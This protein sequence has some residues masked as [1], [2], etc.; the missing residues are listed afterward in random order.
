MH[1]ELVEQRKWISESRFLHALNYCMLLPGPEAQQLATYIGWLMHRTWGGI[2]A[3]TLFVLP[4]FVILFALSWIYV[5]FQHVPLVG[6]LFFGLKAAVLALVVEALVRVAKRA[7]RNRFQ[8]LVAVSAFIA[9][10]VFAVPFPW[11]V[12]GAGLIGFIAGRGANQLHDEPINDANDYVIDRLHGSGALTHVQPSLLRA[13]RILI[14]CLTLW[15]APVIAIAIFVGSRH[16]LWREGVF[17]GQTALITFGGA[18]AALA[19]VAQEVVQQLHWLKP[20]E[21]ID[22]LALA[23]TTPGPLILVLEF[24]GFVAGHRFA[25]PLTPW[26][27]GAL[28]AVVTVWMTF[29]PCFFFIFIGAPYIESLRKN[30]LLRNALAYVTAAVVGVIAN[31]SLWFA[32]HTLFG[33]IHTLHTAALDV[34]VPEWSSLNVIALALTLAAFVALFRFRLSIG[35]ILFGAA[36]VGFVLARA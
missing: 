13:L 6:G 36:V 5:R 35:W 1:S 7:L 33:K 3:G 32:L 15:I 16:V 4:G 31:L 18:Y 28:G 21:M 24:V 26:L 9:I 34:A 8:Y 2:I 29:V 30:V 10:Y 22:G 19:Y 14:V 17:F 12:L 20:G 23:E 25:A 11:I 27:G